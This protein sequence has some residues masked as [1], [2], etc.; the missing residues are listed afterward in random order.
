MDFKQLSAFVA[1]AELKSFS[2][3]AE[4]LYLSQPTV[5]AQIRNLEDELNTRLLIRTTKSIWLTPAGEAL[6][7]DALSI[8]AIQT[9]IYRRKFDEKT[10]ALRIGASTIPASYLLPNVLSDYREKH[11]DF[12]F[13]LR[14]G[15]SQKIIDGVL[16]GLHDIG[17]VGVDPDDKTLETIPVWQDQL[18][19]ITAA[20]EKFRA[21][22]EMNPIPYQTLMAE[23]M[24]FREEGSGSLQSA[25]SFLTRFG[26]GKVPLN[27]IA[28]VDDTEAIR[29]MVARGMGVTIISDLAIQEEIRTGALISFPLDEAMGRRDFFLILRKNRTFSPSDRALIDD[30]IRNLPARNS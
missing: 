18:V 4:R 29:R 21:L 26:F 11:A 5:S 1:V 22:R 9:K 8:L 15:G 3:A 12:Y 23:P 14:Q 25:E 13:E 16:N 2:K 6:Y 27:V 24:I 30:F 7:E 20:N 17:F 19:L 28:R 10:R